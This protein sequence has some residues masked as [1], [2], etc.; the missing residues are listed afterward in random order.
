MISWHHLEFLTK[1]GEASHVPPGLRI[2]LR[3][4]IYASGA[5]QV[6]ANISRIIASAQRDIIQALCTHYNSVF[7]NAQSKLETISASLS[8]S[9]SLLS[10]SQSASHEQMM[11]R[12]KANIERKKTHLAT[13]T[14][15]KLAHQL[16]TQAKNTTRTHTLSQGFHKPG[17][18]EKVAT[19]ATPRART[20]TITPP[21]CQVQRHRRL[22]RKTGQDPPPHHG[23]TSVCRPESTTDADD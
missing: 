22:Q 7:N 8:S 15:R 4:Q 3:P 21:S 20:P 5:S 2:L 11:E 19:K 14:E 12:T 9:L 17:P 16:S 1:C 13:R 18:R 10:P 23:D 6:E